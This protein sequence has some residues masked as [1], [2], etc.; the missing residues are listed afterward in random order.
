MPLK[1]AE[2]S[3]ENGLVKKCD[4]REIFSRKLNFVTQ[5]TITVFEKC[6]IYGTTGYPDYEA[7]ACLAT[8]GW[9]NYFSHGLLSTFYILA[10]C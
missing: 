6:Q 2:D 3:K 10:L 5:Q 8:P 9:I 4:F 7:G 1:K